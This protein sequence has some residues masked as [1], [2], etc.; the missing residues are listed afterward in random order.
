[1]QGDL[2]GGAATAT[3]VDTNNGWQV[4][5]PPAGGRGV[6]AADGKIVE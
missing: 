4:Q 5:T 2:T 1:L 6:T 3:L